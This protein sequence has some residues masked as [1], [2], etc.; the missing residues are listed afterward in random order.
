MSRKYIRSATVIIGN[1]KSVNTPNAL[2]V[3]D[4]KIVFN[5]E[6]DIFGFPNIAQISIY[7]LSPSSRAKIEDEFIKLILIAGYKGN[8]KV[9]FSGDILYLYH[10][11]DGQGNVISEFYVGDGYLNYSTS[12]FNQT[13]APNLSRKDVFDSVAKSFNLQI[14]DVTGIDNN[15]SSIRGQ[16]LSG[17]TKDLLTIQAESM[18]LYWSI[19]DENVIAFPKKGNRAGT[20]YVF[21][22]LNGMIK[23]PVITEIGINLEVL[24]DPN[25]RPGALFKV[26]SVGA[27][28][29]IGSYYFKRVGATFGTGTYR[30]DKLTHKGDTHGSDWTTQIQGFLLI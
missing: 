9:V 1:Q 14:G 12:F 15:A 13:L 26:D 17:P 11:R 30:I 29:S 27:N 23:S 7:N 25:L 2:K 28:I 20:V 21:N 16:T 4:L 24:L 22:A 10:R 19:Q 5:L 3:T 18:G 6:K 8:E